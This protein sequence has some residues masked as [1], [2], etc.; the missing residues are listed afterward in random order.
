MF[1][2]IFNAMTSSAMASSVGQNG[3]LLC[4][5]QGY[6]WVNVEQGN[7]VIEQAQEHC[8]ACLFPHSDDSSADLI[9]SAYRN[10]FPKQ[11][12]R[13]LLLADDAA[14]VQQARFTLS[15]SRA[16]PIFSS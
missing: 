2:L 16:P 15:P 13:I 6:Q 11:V 9:S 5:S 3:M 8:Q 12:N 7:N 10:T 14:V 4:T 1:A